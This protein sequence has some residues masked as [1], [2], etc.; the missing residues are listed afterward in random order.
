MRRETKHTSE[1]VLL[2]AGWVK[3]VRWP[4]LPRELVALIGE[5]EAVVGRLDTGRFLRFPRVS[6][7]EKP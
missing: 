7:E 4:N 2:D 6:P 3:V 1:V 5:H